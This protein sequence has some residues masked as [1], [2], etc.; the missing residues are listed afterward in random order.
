MATITA[1][2]GIKQINHWIGGRVV[3]SKSGRFGPV[4]N[5]ATGEVQAHVDFAS[6]EE[7]D[8]VVACAK[9][10]FAES[11]FSSGISGL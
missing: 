8:E 4:Y 3:G 1:P 10:A 11:S 2:A 5:P 6:V 7:V 9:K